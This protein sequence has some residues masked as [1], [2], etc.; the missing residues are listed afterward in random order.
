MSEEYKRILEAQLWNIANTLRGKMNADEFRDYI[1]GFIFYKYL[2]EKMNIFADEILKQDGIKFKDITPKTE[3]GKEFIEA[4]KEEALEKLG[5]FLRPEELFT[6]VAKRGKGDNEDD[7][8]KFDENKTN[9]ILEDLQKILINI[10]LSTMGTDSEEDYENLFEDMDLNSSK[11]GKTPEARN[12]IIAKV[13][14][15]LDKIDFKL[16]DINQVDVLGDAYEYLIGQFASGAGKKAGEFYTP[17]QVSSILAKLVT[18][19][20]TKLKSVYDPTCGSGSLLLRVAR[21]VEDV[22]NFY[23]QE[24]NRTTY[25][26]ARMN[27]ILHGVHYR[28]FDIKQDDT[29]EHPQHIDK[30]FEAIVANP[31]FS[32]QWSANPL[33]TS[34]DRFSQYGRLA[35]S[36]KAD[37]A[38]VQHMIYHLAD[39]GTMAI[40]LPHGALFRGGAEQHIRK[41]LIENKNFLDAVIGLPA[42]IFYGTSIPTCILVF[43]KCRENPDDVLFIDASNDFE[44]TRNQNILSKSHVDKIIKTYRSRTEIDKYS[45]KAS[46]EEIS[47]NDFNLNV[48]R[49]ISTAIEA[50]TIDMNFVSEK[51][52]S[53]QNT[54]TSTDEEIEEYC[55]QLNIPIPIGSNVPLLKMYRQSLIQKIFSQ[56]I[57]FKNGNEDFPEWIEQ[58]ISDVAIKK[59]SNI[60]ANKIEDNFGDYIIYGASG[61]LKK[62][63]FYEEENDYVSI[64]KDGAGVGRLLY[65]KGN[66]SVLGTL[67]MIKPKEN[68]NTYFLFCLLNNIDFTKYITGSTIPHIY[69]KDWSNETCQIPCMEEQ[70]HISNF[71]YA[72]DRKLEL[73]Q[74]DNLLSE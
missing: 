59:S 55:N 44:K 43:K 49:Y 11:L 31:P 36:S 56:E 69:F 50:E 19:G 47:K 12:A 46:L 61:I 14:T 16:S 5:Y 35:P 34:D 42:N 53:I 9:F 60:S 18:T 10:Q 62:V 57:R 70:I 27:M 58:K 20:K 8:D 23:G 40:V 7:V 26:L 68:V 63:D 21:E 13:L 73:I 38:F 6:E 72:F 45:K 15:H 1:L 25:N 41:Y 65:C 48:P 29:L 52:N 24:M 4:I 74:S 51:L 17:Q 30:Q 66:S 64:V 22:S 28:Q 71:L 2:S 54:I 33:F 32:A 39:N 67:E 37:F 3:N